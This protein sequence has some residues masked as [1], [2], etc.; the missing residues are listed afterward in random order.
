MNFMC[1]LQ[2]LQRAMA[3]LEGGGQPPH[4]NQCL[5]VAISVQPCVSLDH[6]HLEPLR[7]SIPAQSII[8]DSKI[9]R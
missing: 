9:C 7:I 8:D 6:I 2:C 3:H 1:Q 4:R 5:Q